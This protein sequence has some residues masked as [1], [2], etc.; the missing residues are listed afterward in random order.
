MHLTDTLDV[1]G[2]ERVAV[3]LV[4]MLPRERYQTHLCTTR[5]DGPLAD[6]VAED[7]GRL[8]LTRKGRF[9]VRAIG[10]LIA[11]IRKHQVHILHA[12]ETSLFLAA[13]ASLFP[14]HPAVVWH[15]HF[16]GHELAERPAWLYGLAAKRVSGV[17]AV[18]QP[19]ADWSR[20]RLHVPADR[21][22]F[23]PNFVIEAKNNE[24]L[25]DLPGKAGGRIVCVANFRPQKDHPTL[26]HAMGLVIRQEPAAHL[27][28]VGAGSD[29]KYL[30]LVQKHIARQELGGH[31]SLLGQRRDISAILRACDIGVLSSAAEGLPLALLEYGMA[32][33]PAVVTRVG[34][35]AEV[36]EQGRVGTLVPPAAP[37]KLA[38][39]LV[40]LLRSPG[41]RAS[42]G[43]Q[44]HRRVQEVYSPGPIIQKIC[45]VYDAVMNSKQRQMLDTTHSEQPLF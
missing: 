3:D 43:E 37:D 45:R 33:I 44:L 26:L 13:V 2:R 29:R 8:R 31:V 15:D 40:L 20:D 34:Q 12:H 14:P 30:D 11:Y 41:R 38:E 27:L 19:L 4:N 7:V 35:C 17:I 28:L 23:I 32:G 18:N 5:R 10:Q 9:D 42:L 36:L 16:G 24:K 6:L 21:V 22:S 1:G 39:A 25:P